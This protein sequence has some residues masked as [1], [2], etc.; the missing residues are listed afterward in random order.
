MTKK[1]QGKSKS[2]KG[3]SREQTEV[4]AD[5]HD[6]DVSRDDLDPI[7]L[8]MDE[9]E[10]S[11]VLLDVAP[12][13]ALPVNSSGVATP[14]L[15]N[16]EVAVPLGIDQAVA[17][18]PQNNRE[19]VDFGRKTLPARKFN[20]LFAGNRLPENST[21]LIYTEPADHVVLEYCKEDVQDS[22]DYWKHS[23][24]GTLIGQKPIYKVLEYFAKKPTGRF[25]LRSA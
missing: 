21:P 7:C 5:F 15:V 9:G 8:S 13:G 24:I 25:S 22:I 10:D 20:A 1:R 11:E 19:S 16:Q 12:T 2:S 3:K 17:A 4:L 14:L 6:S 23:L 18:P